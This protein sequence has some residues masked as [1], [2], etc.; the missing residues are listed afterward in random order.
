M[1]LTS[2]NWGSDLPAGWSGL[3]R[4]EQGGG[5]DA[6]GGLLVSGHT[7]KVLQFVVLVVGTSLDTEH[8]ALTEQHAPVTTQPAC[9]TGDSDNTALPD[10][11]TERTHIH[12]HGITGGRQTAVSQ[13]DDESET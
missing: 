8:C 11:V 1:R 10:L 9:V 4:D 12:R 2:C 6:D 5:T 13:Q 3:P 7:P